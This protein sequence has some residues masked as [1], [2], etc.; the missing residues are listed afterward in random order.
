MA[1]KASPSKEEPPPQEEEETPAEPELPKEPEI[2][3]RC[4]RLGGTLFYGDTKVGA[5]PAGSRAESKEERS[6][7]KAS[8]AAVEEPK[9]FIRHGFGIQVESAAVQA[10]Y[11]KPQG[12]GDVYESVVVG[13]YEGNWVEDAMSGQ[14]IYKWSDGSVYDGAMLDNKMHGQGRLEWPDGSVY[15]G[16]WLDGFMTGQ[17]KFSFSSG[18]VLEGRFHR[19][20]FL[21]EDGAW[22]DVLS[23]H[24]TEEKAL[25]L[26]GEAS[27]MQVRRVAVGEVFGQGPSEGQTEELLRVLED[28]H[29]GGLVPFLIS[30]ENVAGTALECLTT[31]GITDCA[32]QC[33]SMRL[34]A[35]A[36]R[37]LHDHHR[38]FF[39]AIK[40]SLEGGAFFTLVFED[41]DEGCEMLDQ[42]QA[43]WYTRRVAAD[44]PTRLIPEDWQLGKLLNSVALP[45]EVFQPAYFNH[46]G[47]ARRYLC[48]ADKAEL[49]GLPHPSAATAPGEGEGE[50]AEAGPEGDE[51]AA[52]EAE[53][54]EAA[55]AAG[56]AE[57]AV[58]PAKQ[59]TEAAAA[60]EA[61]A[62]KGL[63]GHF[64]DAKGVPLE[65]ANLQV[66]HC[67]RPAVVSLARLQTGLPDDVA[68]KQVVGRFTKHVPLHR[69]VLVLLCNDV[70]AAAAP[71]AAP[72]A[73]EVE[74][75]N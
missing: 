68:C 57:E 10:G 18:T 25:L 46:R 62:K 30:E 31:L 41:D 74:Y 72:E 4:F 44:V 71:E 15:E 2:V 61:A 9:V 22:A 56:D 13:N 51:A 8:A 70:A 37:R 69:T 11:R 14:G 1:P 23:R 75:V 55:E 28:I 58:D 20:G 3:K 65:A 73:A 17:G 48:E 40:S 32:T 19:N 35:V 59:V 39:R 27:S 26:E 12:G 42:E 53:A 60:P 6:A 49:G 7:S 5:A 21:G 43:D 54:V 16:G 47:M 38:S 34:A 67:L 29:R 36:K 66:M 45:P 63:T 33:A 64:F 24:R 50:G 52:G